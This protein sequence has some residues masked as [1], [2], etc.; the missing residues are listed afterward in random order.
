MEK[1]LDAIHTKERFSAKVKK[2]SLTF[3]MMPIEHSLIKDMKMPTIHCIEEY[4]VG[5]NFKEQK[6]TNMPS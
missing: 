5:T 1:H 6:F 3:F 4:L 2:D